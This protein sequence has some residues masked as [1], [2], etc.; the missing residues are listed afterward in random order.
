MRFEPRKSPENGFATPRQ[1]VQ[2]E[3]RIRFFLP[4][5]KFLAIRE[6]FA[7][8]VFMLLPRGFLVSIVVYISRQPS[9]NF[10]L[11]TI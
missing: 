7:G 4:L 2:P 10:R 8:I 11:F 5:D 6:P 1:A 3:E 9:N